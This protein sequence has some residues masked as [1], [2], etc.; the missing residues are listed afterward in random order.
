MEKVKVYI[1]NITDSIKYLAVNLISKIYFK[2]IIPLELLYFRFKINH[3]DAYNFI[4]NS[5]CCLIIMTAL[6]IYAIIFG[7][8]IITNFLIWI[9]EGVINLFSHDMFDIEFSDD[10]EDEN[11][12]NI[13]DQSSESENPNDENKE[14]QNPEKQISEENSENKNISS[15]NSDKPK[16]D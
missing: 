3:E 10:G 15:E 13:V 5:L 14:N 16:I 8:A 4:L 6:P 11:N 9:G 12:K 7:I 1:N 2:I